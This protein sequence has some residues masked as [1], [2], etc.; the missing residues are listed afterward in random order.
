MCAIIFPGHKLTSEL[1]PGVEIQFPMVYG[2][3]LMRANSGSGKRFTGGPKC[4]FRGKEVP[5]FICCSPKGGITSEILKKML[6]RMDSFN[7]FPR[8]L[9]GPLPF[10]LIDGHGSQLQLPFLRYTNDPDHPWIVCLGLPNRTALWQVGY[11]SEQNG[12]WKTSIVDSDLIV[13]DYIP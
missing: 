5:A 1:H 10:L 12:C 7:L 11:S 9:G 4:S 3:F 13:V 6:E 8:I 2:A